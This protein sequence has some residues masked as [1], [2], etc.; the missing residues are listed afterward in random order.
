MSYSRF[1]AGLRQAEVDV[2]RKML[3]ELAVREPDAFA[4]LVRVAQ[5]NAPTAERQEAAG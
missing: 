2:D 4:A 5:A 3:A 1:I